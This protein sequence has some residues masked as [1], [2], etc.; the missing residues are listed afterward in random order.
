MKKLKKL[1]GFT[2]IELLIVIAII[3][4][5][6]SIVL[7]SLNSARGRANRAAFF[8]EASAARASI[9]TKCDSQVLVFA[10]DIPTDSQN[11][12]W[13]SISSQKCGATGLGAFSVLVKNIRAFEQTDAA[14]CSVYVCDTGLFM[15]AGCATPVSST[16]DCL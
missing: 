7:V 6:A 15:D 12:N 13:D 9:M 5:L 1:R 10:N 16:S 3:G 11:V 2:L 14:A 4:I 8:A